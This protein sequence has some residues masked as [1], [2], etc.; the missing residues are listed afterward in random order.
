M[1][2][3]PGMMMAPALWDLRAYVLTSL[4]WFIMMV[5]MMLPS[6][7]PAILL[8][9]GI[10]RKRSPEARI[11][12]DVWIFALGYLAVWGLFSGVAAAL[13]QVLAASGWVTPMGV[14][15]SGWLSGGVL[16]IAGIYQ[17][18]PVKERCLSKC[19]SPLQFFMFH[20]R[21][22]ALG[23]FVMGAEHGLYCLGC[24]WALMLLLFVAGVMNLLWVAVIA[25]FVLLEKLVPAGDLLGRFAG[26][27]MIVAGLMLPFVA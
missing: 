24:C 3:M 25:I 6:A 10:A 5:G 2:E 20:Y 7:S 17:W 4:M 15:S 13:Q 16:V 21:K 1:G 9:A 11:L 14:S 22:G 8:H 12:P 19:R 27:V 18:L 26:G 23:T